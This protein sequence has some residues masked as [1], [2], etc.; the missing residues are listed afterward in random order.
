MNLKNW[1][2]REEGARGVVENLWKSSDVIYGRSP[3]GKEWWWLHLQQPH[4]HAQAPNPHFYLQLVYKPHSKNKILFLSCLGSCE[5]KCLQFC[6]SI[7]HFW[8][9]FF[10]HGQNIIKFECKGRSSYKKQLYT[11]LGSK[12]MSMIVKRGGTRTNLKLDWTTQKEGVTKICMHCCCA[13]LLALMQS[14]LIQ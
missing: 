14:D 2:L 7:L 8:W 11:K 1:T 3:K 10:F 9:K 4:A 13:I 5:R 6:P 12:P